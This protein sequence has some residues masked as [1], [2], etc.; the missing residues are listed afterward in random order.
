MTNP[1]SSGPV[2]G[3]QPSMFQTWINAVTKPS[4]QTY[5][6]IASSPQ[7]KASTAYIWV[8]VAQ[9]L[10]LWL[11]SVV[12]LGNASF[13]QVLNQATSNGGGGGSGLAG[14]LIAVVCVVPVFALITTFFFAVGIALIQWVAKMF[15]G[16]GT[17]EQLLYTFAAISVPVSLVTGVLNL[18]SLIPFVGFCFR[19]VAILVLLY[20]IV[21]N[22]LAVKGVNQFGFGPAIGALFIPGIVL[23]LVCVCIAVLLGAVVGP[24]LGNV[25][26]SM[27]QSLTSP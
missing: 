3:G 1:M 23:G 19:I 2:S 26:Q 24:V 16:K 25:F 18:F 4:E 7:V 22:V 8:F 20:V 6:Q 11:S 27:N 9:L 21:L 13:N 10:A 14:I 12:A 17:Y 15:G 5:A